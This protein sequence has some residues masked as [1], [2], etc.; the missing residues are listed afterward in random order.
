MPRLVIG[1]N[2]RFEYDSKS[3]TLAYILNDR[4]STVFSD[5][6]RYRHLI[7]LSRARKKLPK[8]K[9]D[10]YTECMKILA[11]GFG[12]FRLA[13]TDLMQMTTATKEDRAS[14]KTFLDELSSQRNEVHNCIELLM[15]GYVFQ[16]DKVG[17]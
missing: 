11:Q 6:D 3:S 17:R 12:S 5:A 15:S 1:P 16:E 14:V 4:K 2:K 7:E 10:P 13:I 9:Q 8:G